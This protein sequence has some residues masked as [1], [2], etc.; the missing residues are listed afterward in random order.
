[1]PESS[2]KFLEDENKRLKLELEQIT[3]ERDKYKMLFDASAD[4][5]SIIDL[6]SGTFVECNQAAVEMHGIASKADFLTLI[7]SDLSPLFQPCGRPSED[8]GKAY[9]EKALHDGAQLFQWTHTRLDG[10]IFP[11]LVSLTAIH[12]N[13][14]CLVLVIGRD[15]TALIE[16]QDK[17]S[18]ALTEIKRYE[19]AYLKE[20]QKFETFVDLAPVGIAINAFDN[21]AFNYVNREF[22]RFT[23][24]N[25][26]ELNE[27]DYWEL[28][29]QSYQA[30]EQ[31]QLNLLSDT[32]RYGPYK[33]EYTHKNGHTYPVLLS[34]IKITDEHGNNVIWSVVQDIS[35]QKT[36]EDQ[37]IEAK[38]QADASNRT[39]QLANDSAGI[40]VWE[41]DLTTNALVWDDWMYKLYGISAKTFTGAFEAWINSVH[42]DDIEGAKAELESAVA[43]LGEYN[44][45]FRVVHPDGCVRTL[46][47]SAEILKDECGQPIKVVGVNYDVTEKVIA[48][49]TLAKAKLAAEN[50]AKAKSDFL[51]NMSHEIRTPMNAILGGLQLLQSAQ[52]EDNL[53]II[54]DNATY[55]AQSLLTIINDILDYSKIESNKLELEQAPFSLVDVVDSV[56]YDLD[57]QISNKGLDFVVTIDERFVD[58]WVGDFVR[59]KQIL[60][61]LVSNA[62]KFTHNGH[63]ELT[64][65]YTRYHD[66]QAVCINVI[67][68][69]IGMNEEAQQKIFERFSQADTS[70]T[71]QY[72]GT[73]L[74]MSIT[75]NLVAL[76]GG[77]IELTS[78]LGKGTRVSVVL[79]LEKTT[80]MVKKN[81][82]Q[83]LLAPNLA[84]KKILIAE[85]NKI[86]QIV[87]QTMLKATYAQLTMVENGLLAVELFA[88]QGFDLVLMD[89]HMP[90]MDGIEAQQKIREVNKQI[91]VIALTANVMANDVKAYLA[92]G[93][94]A[95]IAKPIDMKS[96][97]GVLKQYF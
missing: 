89:I 83:S 75:S 31:E 94:A 45:E 56:K 15:I 7:P 69:G 85:D 91:P 9:L 90:E 93:F 95:H 37:L 30:Q 44:P 23:G 70:T 97:Y 26:D 80:L 11:C 5:L 51:A 41:W 62:V 81:N 42:P 24:Y 48:M 10:S 20:K 64:I 3:F 2:Y 82:A 77:N 17:L 39:M 1:M 59:V 25:V 27:M 57:A 12:F 58:G 52:L 33:K 16:T 6:N 47:A 22:S 68:S 34:G 29:P 96:L 19:H 63:V 50:A 74:G 67:D 72:G 13:E 84:G 38:K 8:M 60:L 54:L 32:G 92:Q 71:R 46:K 87:I 18:A 88:K 28:T 73:G 55:S 21:G 4:A 61:N 40:G 14:T 43:G 86:N 53:R 76:M 35:Q 79:P 78:E 65:D 66:Q 49:N 36:I